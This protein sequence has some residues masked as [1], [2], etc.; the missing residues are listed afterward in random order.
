MRT[1]L[2]L[3]TMF[4]LSTPAHAG[5]E[6]DCRAKWGTDYRMVKYCIEQQRE[7]KNAVNARS[8]GIIG[9][10][11]RTKWRQDYRMV[12]YCIEQQ[13]QARQSI[14]TTTADTT[15]QGACRQKWGTDYRMVKYCI[16]QQSEAKR[17]VDSSSG[18]GVMSVAPYTPPRQSVGFQSAGY[19]PHVSSS[20]R[21]E[22]EP[23][24]V[25]QKPLYSQQV[26]DE[27]ATLCATY[28]VI[29]VGDG[30]RSICGSEWTS[31]SGTD[32]GSP[33]TIAYN[34]HLC[35]FPASALAQLLRKDQVRERN[36]SRLLVQTQQGVE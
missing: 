26:A 4:A 9:T 30:V 21:Q 3:I 32:D 12:K 2:L 5:I 15:I 34:M 17:F 6:S 36:L 22:P 20:M 28:G 8:H 19:G 25:D 35:A 1:L 14:T 7:A 33:E 10:N 13:S 31:I 27:V 11:C 29:T 16:E 24:A 23:Q 18:G